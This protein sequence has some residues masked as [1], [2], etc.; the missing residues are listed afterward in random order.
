MN[1]SENKPSEQMMKLA[2]EQAE[3]ILSEMKKENAENK[4]KQKK[5][6]IKL[7]SMLVLLAVLIAFSTIAWFTMNREVD[8]EEIGMKAQGMNFELSSVD[9]NGFKGL[10]YDPYHKNVREETGSDAIVWLMTDESNFGNYN[11]DNSDNTEEQN[12]GI[13]PGSCGKISFNVKPY[14]DNI[15]L[16]YDFE[17]LGYSYDENAANNADNME[18]LDEKESP[19]R[20]LNGHI[21]LFE[22]RTGTT[23]DDYVY[24][25]PI[26][27]N[28]DMQRVIRSNKYTKNA[29]DEPTQVDIYWVWPMTLSR[30]IDARTCQK[31]TVSESPFTSTNAYN[32]VVENIITYPDYYFKGVTRPAN[33]ND[34]LA[35][36]AIVT[37]YDKY[38]DYYDQADNEIGMGVDFILL[39]MSVSEVSSSG[40]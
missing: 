31:V 1:Y 12:G 33:V 25:K 27:S 38:G 18:L 10:W 24:S 3:L 21:L 14:V 4:R 17:I 2:E 23:K 32:E 39:K 36:T 29:N 37:D 20:F 15:Y 30:L 5:S 16:S 26:L 9:E 6:L 28:A 35:D 34:R 11:S 40:E 8:T 19:A 22:E 7:T 13:K